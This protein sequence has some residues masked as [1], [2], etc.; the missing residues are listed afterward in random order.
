[1]TNTKAYATLVTEHIFFFSGYVLFYLF[2][3]FVFHVNS[4]NIVYSEAIRLHFCFIDMTH[5]LMDISGL[6]KRENNGAQ[7]GARTHNP[8]IRSIMLYRLS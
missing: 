6:I 1:M 5:E 7:R 3:L 2:S 8:E 4:V